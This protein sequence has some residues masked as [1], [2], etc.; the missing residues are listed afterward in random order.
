MHKLT[1]K[2]L[3]NILEEGWA[4]RRKKAEAKREKIKKRVRTARARTSAPSYFSSTEKNK[5]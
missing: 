2:E 5:K 3:S 4:E 1:K